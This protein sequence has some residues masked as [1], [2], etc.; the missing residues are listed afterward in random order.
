VV[1]LLFVVLLMIMRLMMAMLQSK[2]PS[3]DTHFTHN[4]EQGLTSSEK[5]ACTIYKEHTIWMQQFWYTT[6]GC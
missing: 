2:R 4:W 3:R 6:A 1:L 5:P